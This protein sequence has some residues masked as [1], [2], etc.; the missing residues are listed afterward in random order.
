MGR[1]GREGRGH[2]VVEVA[3]GDM[4]LGFVFLDC[5]EGGCY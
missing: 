1:R 4:V 3:E 2:G 5:F